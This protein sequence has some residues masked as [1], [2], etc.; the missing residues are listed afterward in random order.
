MQKA[1]AKKLYIYIIAGVVFCLVYACFLRAG[2]V[3][4]IYPF[5]NKASPFFYGAGAGI[6]LF[7]MSFTIVCFVLRRGPFLFSFVLLILAVLVYPVLLPEPDSCRK[8][9]VAFTRTAAKK[10]QGP[11]MQ[12]RSLN[13]ESRRCIPVKFGD[14]LK[15]PVTQEGSYYLGLGLPRIPFAEGNFVLK[16]YYI[17]ASGRREKLIEEKY[18]LDRS[19]WH[20]LYIKPPGYSPGDVI[21]LQGGFSDPDDRARVPSSYRFY[22]T[23]PHLTRTDKSLNVILILVDTLRADRL[24]VLGGPENISPFFDG[25]ADRG[26]LFSHAFSQ[27]SFTPPSV[28]SM[29]TSRM[30]QNLGMREQNYLPEKAFTMAERFREQGYV[31]GAVSSN[32]IIS[33]ESNFDQGF[34]SFVLHPQP[35]VSYYWDSASWVTDEAIEWLSRKKG[36]ASFLYLHYSD[37]HIPYLAPFGKM[38][39][40]SKLEPAEYLSLPGAEASL[41]A[42]L[43]APLAGSFKKTLAMRESYSNAYESLYNAEVRYWDEEF[44]RLLKFLESSGRRDDTLLIIT[45]DHGEEF[46]EHG[47]YLHGFT[48]YN[49]VIHVPLLLAGPKVP[50]GRVKR[51]VQVADI[52]P[53]LEELLEWRKTPEVVGRSLVPLM[54][55]GQWTDRAFAQ[56]YP[57]GSSEAISLPPPEDFYDEEGSWTI[58]AMIDNN[59]K[60]IEFRHGDGKRVKRKLFHLDQDPAEQKDLSNFRPERLNHE[61]SLLND[62]LDGLPPPLAPEKRKISTELVDTMKA[63]GYIQD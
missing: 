48:L 11:A 42:Y 37:P 50:G 44:G 46:L 9:D 26:L 55:G 29:F 17:K 51:T 57:L 40:H 39:D 25:L 13:H 58:F 45:S 36:G 43:N 63:L 2:Y 16:V 10:E 5:V 56:L 41:A 30:P 8:L 38:V 33:P 47:Y 23:E 61:R 62:Y 49:E 52:F 19:R 28:A 6:F 60:L 32:W 59:W 53:T 34:D 35:L 18:S 15:F 7:L 20:D 14:S 24:G 3:W 4:R 54:E 27:S 12:K 22:L 31:T 1:K 21:V